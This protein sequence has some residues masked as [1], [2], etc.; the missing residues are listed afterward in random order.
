MGEG[1][2]SFRL[3]LLGYDLKYLYLHVSLRLHGVQREKFTSSTKSTAQDTHRQG[4]TDI[5]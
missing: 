3:V 2:G 5:T 4:N 1:N